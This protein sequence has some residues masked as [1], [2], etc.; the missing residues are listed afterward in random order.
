LTDSLPAGYT[1]VSY[2]SNRYVYNSGTG[3]WSVGNL[4]NGGSATTITVTVNATGVMPTKQ[5]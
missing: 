4:A 5:I 1:F 2:N 3:V